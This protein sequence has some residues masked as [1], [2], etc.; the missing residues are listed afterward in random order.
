MAQKVHSEL[1]EIPLPVNRGLPL[2]IELAVTGQNP[3]EKSTATIHF[4]DVLIVSRYR[5]AVAQPHW[6]R[7]ERRLRKEAGNAGWRNMNEMVFRM[8]EAGM[9]A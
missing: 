7:A 1:V 2:R 8:T 4:D 6:E 3:G 9:R 5:S